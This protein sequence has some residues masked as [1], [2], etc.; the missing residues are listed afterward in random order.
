MKKFFC[1][2]LLY[3]LPLI[4]IIVTIVIIDPYY[5]YHKNRAFNQ[6]IYDVGYS[7]DQGR[8]FKLF[9]YLNNPS[10]KI[11]LGA[12]EINLI[13]ERNIP[14]EGWHSL[15]FGGAQLEESLDL[16]WKIV[17]KNKLKK[18]LLAPE[19]IKFYNAVI[20]EEINYYSWIL[21]QSN[22]AIELYNNKLEYFL[23]KY[24]L[25]SIYYLLMYNI[26]VENKRSKPQMSK[27][28]FWMSQLNYARQQCSKSVNNSKIKDI[29][30]SFKEIKNYCD[31]IGIEVLI[32]LPI[33]HVD[34]IKL[35]YSDQIYPI[36]KDYLSHL[37]NIFGSVYYFDYPSD[38]SNN[39]DLFSDPFHFIEAELYINSLWGN[40]NNNFILLDSEE[41]L[42]YV[43]ALRKAI[44][45]K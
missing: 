2:G 37:I 8:R 15:S 7:Y 39:V 6:T 30:S 36:Y 43:D 23:D 11:I 14:E 24:T 3:A 45:I 26:G 33:Q 35:E 21:T 5:L 19:F 13:S 4:V 28:E 10:D 38:F 9:T 34:L 32:V 29:Y 31:S 12:S 18:V 40:Q 42:K 27:D 44:F 20:D 16:F 22:N 17:G 1:R 25:Q 41:S